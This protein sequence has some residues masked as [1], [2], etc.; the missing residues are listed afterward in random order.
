MGR[1]LCLAGL[2]V[3]VRCWATWH[4]PAG[5]PPSAQMGGAGAQPLSN[6]RIPRSQ[7]LLTGVAL[8]TPQPGPGS[9]KR[10]Q[11]AWA[12]LTNQSLP[13]SDRTSRQNQEASA[14]AGSLGSSP[15]RVWLGNQASRR[16]HHLRLP[17]PCDPFDRVP[18]VSLLWPQERMLGRTGQRGTR[19][20][21]AC[22]PASTPGPA[23]LSQG[24][25]RPTASAQQ[26]QGPA[27]QW[28]GS[29]GSRRARVPLAAGGGGRTEQVCWCG[30]VWR[31]SLDAPRCSGVGHRW[32]HRR[33]TAVAAVRDVPPTAP[34][35]W[36]PGL[37]RVPAQ[38]LVRLG[39]APGLSSRSSR[40]A[41]GLGGR[42]T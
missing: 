1:Y 26:G 18:F 6:R 5:V 39:Q 2:G 33:G 14:P 25:P 28:E 10:N 32:R 38:T 19:E 24:L 11:V 21:G 9:G 23:A 41:A 15:S 12:A 34:T 13:A 37:A 35:G 40:A 30:L 31:S 22:G 20:P 16:D 27:A 4:D 8:V 29:L 17:A 36:Q 7:S 42:L 3:S